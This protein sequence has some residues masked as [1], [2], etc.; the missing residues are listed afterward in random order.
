[1]NSCC[2]KDISLFLLPFVE[3]C[4]LDFIFCSS[5]LFDNNSSL[6]R[7]PRRQPSSNVGMESEHSVE[8][9]QH[10]IKVHI[11]WEGHK[12]LQNLHRR[13]VLCSASQ[14]Y[15]G[16]FTKFCGLLRIYELYRAAPE[17]RA[18]KNPSL[19]FSC[20]WK[21]GPLKVLNQGCSPV[22]GQTVNTISTRGADYAHH[23]TTSPSG[24]SDLVTAL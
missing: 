18:L 3:L 16:D 8:L 14:I 5:I 23:S 4:V 11:F 19:P 6:V 15:G 1:M 9:F 17:Y 7:S 2:A 21:K 12:F 13:F 22:F 20:L 10:Y 24:F